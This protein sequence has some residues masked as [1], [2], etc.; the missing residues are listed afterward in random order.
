MRLNLSFRTGLAMLA[1]LLL[2]ICGGVALAL[3]LTGCGEDGGTAGLQITEKEICM[4]GLEGEYTLL[5]VTDSHAVVPGEAASEQ[6]EEYETQRY[7]MFQGEDGA[8][9]ASRFEA[10][11]RY[12]NERQVDALVLGGDI[13]DS[14]SEA[15]LSWL[16]AQLAQLDMPYIYVPGNHDWT[17]PWEY[18]TEEGQEKYLTRLEPFMQGN[19]GVHTLELAEFTLVGIDD[20]PNQVREEAVRELEQLCEGEKPLIVVAHVPFLTQSVLGRAR[21]VWSGGV[22]IGGGNYGGIYPDEYSDRF[23]RLV[24]GEQSP[25]ELVL[26]GHVHFYDE[27][28]MDGERQVLQLVGGP[29][30][31]GSGL[32]LHITGGR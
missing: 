17:Y 10:V 3:F 32:L 1:A 21:E 15:N 27:D 20:S 19:T 6:E 26:A 29:G 11:I 9:S 22:V 7:A 5:F 25:V 16:S 8:D 23:V 4:E 12:A 31:E 30:Y 24:T 28:V 14:P 2:V 13:I 18:M